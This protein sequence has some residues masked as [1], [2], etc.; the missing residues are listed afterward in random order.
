[1]ANPTGSIYLQANGSYTWM[2]G[3]IYEIRQTDQ[4]EA[5]AT[6][7]SFG[8]IGVENQPHQ[9]L[10]NKAQWL[11]N[12]VTTIPHGIASFSA[13]RGSTNS[14]TFTVPAYVT[15][16]GLRA[17]GQG[18]SGGGSI[19]GEYT[20]G[21][22]GGGGQ[23]MEQVLVVTPGQTINWSITATQTVFGALSATAGSDA[24]KANAY[25]GPPYYGFGVPGPGGTGGVGSAAVRFNGISGE[26][27]RS[28]LAPNSGVY[29]VAGEG[30]SSFGCGHSY[31]QWFGNQQSGPGSPGVF[32]GQ[33]GGGGVAGGAGGLGGPGVII[34]TW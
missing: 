23:Y 11:Y 17:W 22:G 24:G 21:G 32:P 33:G 29:T 14:G 6:G 10:L 8:G 1:M 28:V 4:V 27:G 34:V 19:S 16:I 26:I 15:A 20:S 31:F 2:D 25:T 5:A 12:R 18:G 9:I 7:A 30:G 3:D 13:A